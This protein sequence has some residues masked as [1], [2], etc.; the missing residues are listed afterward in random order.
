MVRSLM[1]LFCVAAIAAPAFADPETVAPAGN[2]PKMKKVCRQKPSGDPL[3]P[4]ITCK[5]VPI[6]DK[7]AATAP[8][9]A[10]TQIA[11]NAAATPH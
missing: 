5:S 3:H 4:Y 1:T 9:P 7:V 2:L 10:D 6:V 11:Q 8:A